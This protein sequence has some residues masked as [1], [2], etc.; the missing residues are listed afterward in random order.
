MSKS[1]VYIILI[2]AAILFL[3]VAVSAIN[4][5]QYINGGI[6]FLDAQV[7]DFFGLGAYGARKKINNYGKHDKTAGNKSGP[8]DDG[9]PEILDHD[10][11]YTTYWI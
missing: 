9:A 6:A 2:C 7:G 3:A 1:R 8:Y 10:Y 4:A 11:Y 5:P